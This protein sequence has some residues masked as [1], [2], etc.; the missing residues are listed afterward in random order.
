MENIITNEEVEAKKL[1]GT[2]KETKDKCYQV[3]KE[4]GAKWEETPESGYPEMLL[5]KNEN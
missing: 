4:L 2:H 1:L 5:K 3:L